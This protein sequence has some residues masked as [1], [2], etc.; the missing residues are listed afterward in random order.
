MRVCSFF[1][2]FAVFIL[3]V[4]LSIAGE[5]KTISPSDKAAL[6]VYFSNEVP[7][8]GVAKESK[9]FYIES[10]G[11]YA[12]LIV[13][14]YPDKFTYDQIKV[15]IYKTIRG[16]SSKFD[17]KTYDI[18]TSYY[19]T[20]VKY[21]FYSEG[22]YIFD[23]YNKYDR[24][25]GTA[26]VNIYFSSSSSES[27]RRRD[28]DTRTDSYQNRSTDCI[29]GYKSYS[30]NDF[31]FSM[32]IPKDAYEAESNV[33]SEKVK[34]SNFYGQDLSI[35]FIKS[36]DQSV[37]EF[38]ATVVELTRDMLRSEYSSYSRKEFKMLKSGDEF[39]VYRSVVS[40]V[41]KETGKTYQSSVFYI[42]MH[43][44]RIRDNDYMV[45]RGPYT[46]PSNDTNYQIIIELGMIKF[47]KIY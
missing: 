37:S 2:L 17:D 12:Y 31:G 28:T 47:L 11:G 24:F 4:N 8:N 18:N 5:H 34:L 21:S 39:S 9:E 23:V 33:S 35:T 42:K 13:D 19:Y 7:V 30:N 20:Y 36:I 26:K 45:I 41:Y 14:N 6:R 25:L 29:T 38:D 40:G 10:S 15:K 1:N 27:D 46:D 16:T 3:I 43:N 44:Q 22:E 32:C